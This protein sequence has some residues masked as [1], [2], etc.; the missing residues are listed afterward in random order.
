MGWDTEWQLEGFFYFGAP[1][2][3]WKFEVYEENVGYQPLPYHRIHMQIDDDPDL[4]NRLWALTQTGSLQYYDRLIMMNTGANV[5]YKHE[6]SYKKV[7]LYSLETQYRP[8]RW[9]YT[10]WK[11][12]TLGIAFDKTPENDAVVARMSRF[13]WSSGYESDMNPENPER[14]RR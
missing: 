12:Y 9:P 6:F 11:G 10:P 8:S 3:I 1:L 7:W 13:W 14:Y 4:F 5:Q 2:N